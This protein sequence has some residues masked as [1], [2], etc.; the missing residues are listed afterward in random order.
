MADPSEIWQVCLAVVKVIFK[1]TQFVISI[2]KHEGSKED[3]A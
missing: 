2:R 3:R 1:A